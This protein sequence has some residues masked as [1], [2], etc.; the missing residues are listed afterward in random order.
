[1]YLAHH[2]LESVVVIIMITIT[3]IT[4][5]IVVVI[6]ITIITIITNYYTTY[7]MSLFLSSLQKGMKACCSLYA[8]P[9]P[10][11]VL[12]L[13]CLRIEHHAFLL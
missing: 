2:E 13:R 6:I 9:I 4:I 8:Y 3:I 1:M 11:K 5:I 12:S 10:G 7:T